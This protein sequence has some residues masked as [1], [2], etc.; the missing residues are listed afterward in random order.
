MDPIR[1]AGSDPIRHATAVGTE[2]RRDRVER[3]GGG[4][5]TALARDRRSGD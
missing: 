5:Q 2:S 3:G 4:S 1:A